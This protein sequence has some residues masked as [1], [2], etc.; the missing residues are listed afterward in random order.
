MLR[1]GIVYLLTA[2][3]L[4]CSPKVHK[5]ETFVVKPVPL[6]ALPESQI[7]IPI[8]ISLKSLSNLAEQN[9]STVYTSPNW[10]DGWV[11]AD[12]ATRYKYHFR[13][14]PLRLSGNGNTFNLGFTGF[15]KIIGSTRVCAGSTVLSPWT[16]PCKCGFDEGERRVNI[17]FASTFEL[18][19]NHQLKLK[20]SRSEPQP[21]DKCTVCFWGQ[22]ITNEVINGLKAELDLSKKAIEDSFG[23]VNLRLYLQQV[24]NKLNEVYSIPGIG[25][26][27]LHPKKLHMENITTNNELLNIN[28]G[29]S[30]TPVVNFIKPGEQK[31][32]V[33]DLTPSGTIGGFNIHLE[34]ALQYDS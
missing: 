7:N 11:N 2:I 14:S 4:S 15:Y 16:P 34:A 23:T 19:Q 17:G 31:T 5:T 30:A 32:S 9:V 20:I 27:A 18:K 24:W 6:A 28:I 8:K 21:L 29:I 1:E 22:D 33:P 12:C 3:L 26:L 13:R 25:Y 10:P